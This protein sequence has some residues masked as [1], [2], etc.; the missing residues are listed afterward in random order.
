MAAVNDFLK[1][2]AWRK[3]TICLVSIACATYLCAIN[4]LTGEDWMKLVGGIVALFTTADYAIKRM[5][6]GNGVDK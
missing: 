1:G 6:N 5:K 2:V 4:I 3:F